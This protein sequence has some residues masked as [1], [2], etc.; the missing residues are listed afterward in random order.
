VLSDPV[1]IYKDN[2]KLV[3]DDGFVKVA[4]ICTADL[5]AACAAAGIQ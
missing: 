3:T 1:A 2:V 5:A 4:D